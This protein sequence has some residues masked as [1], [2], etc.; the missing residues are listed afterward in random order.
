MAKWWGITPDPA[1]RQTARTAIERGRAITPD[2][3]ELGD[4]ARWQEMV[5]PDRFPY[6]RPADPAEVA[7]VAV[8]LLSPKAG[9]LNGTVVDIDGGGQWIGPK[10]EYYGTF[11][12]EEQL[13]SVYGF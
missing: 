3:A 2:S 6:K 4:A 10:G 7:A 8:M 5:E 12:S 9:Y 11:P 13:K 1:Y